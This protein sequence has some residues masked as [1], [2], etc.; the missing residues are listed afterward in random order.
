MT[1]LKIKDNCPSCKS[2]TLTYTNEKELI[3]VAGDFMH[4]LV[5]ECDN[6]KAK[7]CVFEDDAKRLE[8]N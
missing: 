4:E 3:D 6:C 8:G 1:P 2:T 5:Y 7:V